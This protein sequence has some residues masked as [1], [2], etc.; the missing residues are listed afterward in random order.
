MSSVGVEEAV[1]QPHDLSVEISC[2]LE[3]FNRGFAFFVEL[4]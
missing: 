4:L 2:L 3:L 1:L